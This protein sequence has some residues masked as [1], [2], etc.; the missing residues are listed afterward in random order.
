[1]LLLQEACKGR[2]R[3]GGMEGGMEGG[4]RITSFLGGKSLYYR[5]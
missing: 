3:K 5:Y 4:I 1:M 2:E